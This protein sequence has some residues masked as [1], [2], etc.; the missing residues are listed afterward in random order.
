LTGQQGGYEEPLSN[1]K[2]PDTNTSS[3]LS[4]KCKWKPS[5]AMEDQRRTKPYSC[6]EL[7]W[8][9]NGHKKQ[10]RERFILP[11]KPFPKSIG[12]IPKSS[13]KKRLNASHWIEKRT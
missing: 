10:K 6:N 9:N 1:Y 12:D 11:S 7:M 3:T 13:Q 5:N 2:A 8:L 4:Y